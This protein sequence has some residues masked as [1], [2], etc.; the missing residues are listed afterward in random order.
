MT[1]ISISPAPSAVVIHNSS[2][3]SEIEPVV[4]VASQ[5]KGD[6]CVSSSSDLS[7]DKNCPAHLS[8]SETSTIP[9][10][11]AR[12]D[13][14]PSI[15]RSSVKGRK[16]NN[17][18]R[19]SS[20]HFHNSLVTGVRERPFTADEDKEILHYSA[21]D[22]RRFRREARIILRARAASQ[23]SP[24]DGKDGESSSLTSFFP[25]QLAGVV[26]MFAKSLVGVQSSEFHDHSSSSSVLVDSLYLF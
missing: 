3:K 11:L 14:A 22:M 10:D 25:S 19:K 26:Q 8:V 9:T 1:A 4:L 5:Q 23:Q 17:K 15:L 24:Y 2:L 16:Q 6:S 20:V 18:G 12:S 13:S 7:A 21:E